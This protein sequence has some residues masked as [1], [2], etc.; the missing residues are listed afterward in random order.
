MPTVFTDGTVLTG[1]ALTAALAVAT[2]DASG[3]APVSSVAGRT[4]AV[5]LAVADIS[6]AYPSANPAGYIT[7]ANAVLTGTPTAPTASPGDNDTSIATTAFVAAAVVAAT[8]G[9]ASFNTRTG[10]ITLTS[11]DVT[12]A[13]TFTPQTAAQVSTAVGTETT[14]ATTAEAL[15]APKASPT[16]TGTPAAP[17]VA[18]TAAA[19][20]T[21]IATTAFVRNGTT[22]NDSA[23][24]GQVGEYISA[25]VA[26]P[27]SGITSATTANVTSISLTA[28]DWDVRGNAIF[29]AAGS[30]ALSSLQLAIN[31]TSAT[32]PTPP[33]ADAYTVSQLTFATGGTQGISTGPTRISVASTTTVYLVANAAFTTSTMTAY[34]SISARRIR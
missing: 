30:T 23:F 20:T 33:N 15:L 9:V 21:Q 25:S 16:F 27:G 3:S 31:T 18:A 26:S 8:T 19:G 13:L 24:S 32:L 34:G 2:A 11:S 12:T 6:G 14:R 29:I 10:G 17:T 1:P 4:G 5:T 7:G 28:G 22:T